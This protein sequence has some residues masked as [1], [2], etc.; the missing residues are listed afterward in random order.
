MRS[1]AESPRVDF[2]VVF[3][4]DGQKIGALSDNK[5]DARSPFL[6]DQKLR[7][8]L[9]PAVSPDGTGVRD[10]P[11]IVAETP[12]RCLQGNYWT[13]VADGRTGVAVLNRGAMCSVREADGGLSIPLAYSMYYVW[14]ARIL[15]GKYAYE[16][17]LYPFRGPWQNADLHRKALEYNFPFPVTAGQPGNGKLGPTMTAFDVE[18]D[19]V[20]LSALFPKAG[21]AHARFFEYLGKSGALRLGFSHSGGRLAETDLAGRNSTP[22]TGPLRFSPWQIKT[23]RIG[24]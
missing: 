8:R 4:F 16:F 20:I 10:L 5:R 18:S 6:H 2:R 9:K 19:G 24:D 3:E 17:A 1:W 15:S 14:G 23:L 21:T 11:F 7:F 22:F 13:A 12:D